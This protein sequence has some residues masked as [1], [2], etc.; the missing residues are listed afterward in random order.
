MYQYFAES[1]GLKWAGGDAESGIA[2]YEVAGVQYVSPDG[3]SDDNGALLAPEST[4]R[5][6]YFHSVR[7]GA[8][9]DAPHMYYRIRAVNK[10]FAIMQ[11][12]LIHAGRKQSR[13]CIWVQF[14]LT[15]T[16][17]SHW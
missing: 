13:T 1:V 8:I 9:G 12:C 2:D 7:V 4:H 6:N 16:L 3:L 11:T 14:L 5:Q 15:R 10:Y 17:P